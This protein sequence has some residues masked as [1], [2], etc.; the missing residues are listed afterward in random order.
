MQAF[1]LEVSLTIP[2]QVS[3]GLRASLPGPDCK[4]QT[5]SA[6]PGA[7]SR[8]PQPWPLFSPGELMRVACSPV[9]GVRQLRSAR[10]CEKGARSPPGGIGRLGGTPPAAGSRAPAPPTSSGAPTSSSPRPRRAALRDSGARDPEPFGPRMSPVKGQFRCP[11]ASRAL[12]G[13]I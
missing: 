7:S 8:A 3:T 12:R 2:P 10:Y 5:K 13:S 9:P 11:R 4:K 6:Q 1:M